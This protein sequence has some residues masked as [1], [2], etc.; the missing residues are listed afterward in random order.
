VKWLQKSAIHGKKYETIRDKSLKYGVDRRLTD[1]PSAPPLWARFYEIETNKPMFADRDGAKRSN[2]S[3]VGEE[4]RAK[5]AWYGTWADKVLAE[6]PKW[7]KRV[8]VA[9]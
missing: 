4:R 6:Y 7:A 5:Y 2:L 9:G 8:G 3:E 1:D